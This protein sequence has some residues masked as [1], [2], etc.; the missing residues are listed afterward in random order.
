MAIAFGGSGYFE[1]C[2]G[3]HVLFSKGCKH[4][5]KISRVGMIKPMTCIIYQVS[6]LLNA[7]VNLMK[8]F[9]Y[10]AL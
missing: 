2:P 6:G 3:P 4:R 9:E 7:G 10:F 1:A 8:S 5:V